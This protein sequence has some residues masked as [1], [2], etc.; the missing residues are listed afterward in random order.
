MQERVNLVHG[1]FS[2]ESKPGKGTRI[3]AT[4]PFTPE[5][6]RTPDDT[7]PNNASTIQ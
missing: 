4:V 2:V 3:T 5:N 1:T 7:S 6:D